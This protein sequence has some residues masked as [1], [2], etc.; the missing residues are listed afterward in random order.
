MSA[1]SG[2]DDTRIGCPKDLPRK[3][4]TVRSPDGILQ[5]QN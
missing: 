4:T 3:Y 2:Q 5:P 1:R